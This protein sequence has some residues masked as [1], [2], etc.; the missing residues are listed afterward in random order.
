MLNSIRKALVFFI[1]ICYNRNNLDVQERRSMNNKWILPETPSAEQIDKIVHTTGTNRLAAAVLAVRGFSPEQARTFLEKSVAELHDPF[2]FVDMEKAVCRIEQALGGKEKITVFGDYDADGITSSAVL[3]HCLQSLGADVSYYIPEREN[4]GY[5]MSCRAIDGIA[6][7]GASLIIS[8]D[9]GITA[10]EECSY[11]KTLGVDL[12]VTD[13]HEC[14][15]ILPDAVAVIDP[16]RPG[17]GYPDKNL[18]G[19]GVALKLCQA[20]LRSRQ[21]AEK[22]AEI[23]AEFVALGTIADIAPLTGENRVLCAMGLKKMPESE[24]VGFQALLELADLKG[25]PID[26]GKVGFQL[27]P[28]IN[29]VGRLANAA[30]AV[31]MFLTEDKQEAFRIAQDLEQCN[32]QRQDIEQEILDEAVK[33]VERYYK[34]DRI[35]VLSNKKWHHGVVGIVASRLMKKYNKPCILISPGADGHYKGSGRSMDGFSLYDA[36]HACQDTLV[37]FGGHELAAGIVI[38][39]PKVDAFRQEI[40]AYAAEKLGNAQ[41]TP[42][43]EADCELRGRHLNEASVQNLEVLKPYGAGNKQPV[44]VIK[45]V[46]VHRINT[47]GSNGQHLRMQLCKDGCLIEAVAFGFGGRKDITYGSTITVMANIEMNTYRGVQNVQL[48]IIDVK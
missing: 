8:V 18:A 32:R 23:Y 25:K 24:N 44:F 41:I 6:Q 43:L 11:A 26:S 45:N 29:A 17:C 12:I 47:I 16:K 27:A 37:R 39:S 13:H 48:K 34:D 21:P 36:L 7:T 2:L 4:E 38:D 31:E 33:M 35:L 15:E 30:R 1:E 3:V 20:L 5:G 10:V 19:V 28:K 40:N 9:C 14:G 46:L 22:T 42:V